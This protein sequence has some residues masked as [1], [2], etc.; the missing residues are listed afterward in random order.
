M[1]LPSAEFWNAVLDST[2]TGLFIAIPLT[3]VCFVIAK[4][5]ISSA[6][7]VVLPMYC[8]YMLGRWQSQAAWQK[9]LDAR[10]EALAAKVTSTRKK[11]DDDERSE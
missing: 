9:D 4:A 3:I 2:L 11:G 5:G 10:Y 8:T 6:P 7:V 1:K